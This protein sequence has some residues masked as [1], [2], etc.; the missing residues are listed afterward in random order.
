MWNWVSRESRANP[1]QQKQARPAPDMD[2][3]PGTRNNPTDPNESLIISALCVMHY[4]HGVQLTR[5]WTQYIVIQCT[6]SIQL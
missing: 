1:G 2:A 6:V 4:T 5:H 3:R